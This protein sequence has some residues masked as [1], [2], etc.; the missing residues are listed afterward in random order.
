MIQAPPVFWEGRRVS[1]TA[2]RD[3]LKAGDLRTARGMLG[4]LYAAF[5]SSISAEIAV[6]KRIASIS[7]VTFAIVWCSKRCCS[8]VGAELSSGGA[9]PPSSPSLPAASRQARFKKRAMP[10]TLRVFHGFTCS[11]GPRYIS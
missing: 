1:S 10:S 4:H 5:V 7:S 6:L 9:L 3:A 2:I 11:S 8:R